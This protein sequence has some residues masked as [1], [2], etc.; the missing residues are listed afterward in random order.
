MN[1]QNVKELRK[2]GDLRAA[3]SAALA[4]LKADPQDFL[5]KSQLHWVT[6]DEIKAAVARIGADGQSDPR[7]RRDDINFVAKRWEGYRE[8]DPRVP[9]LAC[10]MIVEQ[11]AKIASELG[12]FADVVYWLRMDGLREEDWSPSS[13]E[14]KSYLARAA[15]IALALCKW[16]KAHPNQATP[17]DVD[18]ALHWL[19]E[20]RAT[21][22]GD[23]SLWL[24]WNAAILLRQRGSIQKATELLA[25]V[26]K[27]KRNEFWVWA[28]AGRLY[29]EDQPGLALSCFCRALECPADPKFL[30]KV[31]REL[32]ELLAE[33]ENYAQASREIS[34]CLETREAHGWKIGRELELLMA[35]PWY[36][37]AYTQAEDSKAFYA[38]HSPSAMALCFDV[39]ETKAATYLGQFSPLAQNES[40][41]GRKPKPLTRFAVRDGQGTSWTIV[42]QR[43]KGVK[44]EAGSPVVIVVGRTEGEERQS[45]VHVA[46]RPEGKAW[47]CLEHSPGVVTRSAS[48]EKKLKVFATEIVSEM[49]VD[50]LADVALKAGDGVMIGFAR[51]QKNNRLFAFH[52]RSAE[53]PSSGV[54]HIRGKMNRNPKGFAFVDDAYVSESL[55]RSLDD[56]VNDVTAL[57]ILAQHP[58][59]TE[60]SWCVI[61]LRADA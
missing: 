32:A 47:D 22:V 12:C 8:S 10:S 4:L 44:I 45:I 53:L 17:A 55:V 29:C 56:N 20:W 43:V 30:G 61:T 37:P 40:S 25:G 54:R 50:S 3:R 6:Y 42:G 16:I 35:K 33:L 59:K 52:V 48:A 38:R 27:A 34:H 41:D 13:V 24:D 57:A 31:R 2:A 15:K 19:C 1:W 9:D 11:L 36:D 58:K 5:A 46:S 49:V 26:I 39:V 18:M 7:F 23:Q 60:R 28:E 21:A 14:D 51:N